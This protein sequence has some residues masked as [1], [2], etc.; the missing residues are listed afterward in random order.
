[1][2]KAKDEE[3]KIGEFSAA[4]IERYKH[5][6]PVPRFNPPRRT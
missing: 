5:K 1:M 3:K 2:T 6:K 4:A